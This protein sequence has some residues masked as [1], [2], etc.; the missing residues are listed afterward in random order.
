MTITIERPL[1]DVPSNT[2]DKR[3]F[4]EITKDDSSKTLR[5]ILTEGYYQGLRQSEDGNI[6]HAVFDFGDTGE[7]QSIPVREFQAA[8]RFLELQPVR[9]EGKGGTPEEYVHITDKEAL[10]SYK[11]SADRWRRLRADGLRILTNE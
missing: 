9:F 2:K 11:L 7:L 5:L 3:S 1:I 4:S 6:T 10:T 8:I